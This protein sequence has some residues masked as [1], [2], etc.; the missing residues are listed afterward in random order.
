MQLL[1]EVAAAVCNDLTEAER[2]RLLFLNV[3]QHLSEEN[4]WFG[5][6][7]CARVGFDSL[8]SNSHLTA[9]TEKHFIS[10]QDQGFLFLFDRQV[11]LNLMVVIIFTDNGPGSITA[12]LCVKFHYTYPEECHASSVESV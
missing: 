6:G 4:I 7:V 8:E 10:K 9:H 5:H 12:C 2:I 11:K 1:V 3:K